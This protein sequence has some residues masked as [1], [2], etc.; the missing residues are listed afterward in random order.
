MI[1]MN[2]SGSRQK[3]RSLT[4]HGSRELGSKK[5]ASS[6]ELSLSGAV[7][8]EGLVN[9]GALAGRVILVLED[10]PLIALD[11]KDAL[12]SADA[13]VVVANNL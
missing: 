5:L 4:M 11:V 7:R 9:G 2:L 13:Q 6:G 10:Q 12:E 3:S 1:G 8:Y